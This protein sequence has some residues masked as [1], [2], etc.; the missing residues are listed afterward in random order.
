[1]YRRLFENLK[2]GIPKSTWSEMAQQAVHGKEVFY[3]SIF[4]PITGKQQTA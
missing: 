2:I 1:M 3:H 4:T